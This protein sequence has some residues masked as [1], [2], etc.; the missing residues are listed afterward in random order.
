MARRSRERETRFF[1]AETPFCSRFNC[2]FSIFRDERNQICA[3]AVGDQK[4]G[5]PDSPQTIEETYEI[6]VL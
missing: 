2:I 3:T 6:D 1:Y 5:K 4:F